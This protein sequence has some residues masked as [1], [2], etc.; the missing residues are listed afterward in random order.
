MSV[1]LPDIR[2]MR[3][4]S[5]Y[6]LDGNSV[7]VFCRSC[8]ESHFSSLCINIYIFF[9]MKPC[10]PLCVCKRI[11]ENCREFGAQ[12]ATSSEKDY[13]YDYGKPL[14]REKLLY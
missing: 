4:Y 9:I 1:Y 7:T 12:A 6:D 2:C 10:V 14:G 3:L 13:S 11:S 5:S 8:F